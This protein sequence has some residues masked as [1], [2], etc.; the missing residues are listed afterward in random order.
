MGTDMYTLAE[1]RQPDGTWQA[2]VDNV[3]PDDWDEDTNRYVTFTAHPFEGPRNRIM[4]DLFVD[5]GDSTDV[6]VIDRPRG[7]PRD[8]SAPVREAHG[9]DL[10]QISPWGYAGWHGASWLLLAELLAVDYSAMVPSETFGPG[11]LRDAL[12]EWYFDTLDALEK[13]G[14]PDA[15]RIVVWF[16]S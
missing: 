13:L 2:V 7:L 5:E 9:P 10:D 12:G 4:F 8:V 3:F 16:G 15:V 6:P 14:P 1:V 11:P